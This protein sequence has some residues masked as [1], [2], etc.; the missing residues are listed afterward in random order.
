MVPHRGLH[1]TPPVKP[2]EPIHSG[3]VVTEA[4]TI[5]SRSD[6]Q[7]T[8]VV[9]RRNE[10]RGDD[11]FS[12][13][14]GIQIICSD[15]HCDGSRDC[16]DGSD[17]ALCGI[18]MLNAIFPVYSHLLSSNMGVLAN[19]KDYHEHNLFFFIIMFDNREKEINFLSY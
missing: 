18:E 16:D 5:A 6:H 10:C 8:E 3:D 17:E 13:Q 7:V 14:D 12:C 15:Q 9:E 11:T 19:M 2:A 1:F 4:T